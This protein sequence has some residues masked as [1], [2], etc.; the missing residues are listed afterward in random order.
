MFEAIISSVVTGRV[1]RKCFDTWDEADRYADQ[2]MFQ[3]VRPKNRRDYR[4]EIHKRELPII[5]RARRE[6]AA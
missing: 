4:V 1:H 2:W 3:G 6:A 5:R